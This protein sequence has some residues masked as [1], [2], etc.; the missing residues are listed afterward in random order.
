[1]G[2]EVQDRYRHRSS[3]LTRLYKA[4]SDSALAIPAVRKFENEGNPAMWTITRITKEDDC[5]CIS[6]LLER[7]DKHL[8]RTFR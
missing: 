4:L 6:M 7:E 5:I 3:D 8:P 2:N 1:M